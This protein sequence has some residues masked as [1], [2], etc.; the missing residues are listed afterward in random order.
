M[1]LFVRLLSIVA[2]SG[3]LN[4]V[5]CAPSSVIP[6][7]ENHPAMPNAESGVARPASNTLMVG[8]RDAMVAPSKKN[9]N[10]K[11]MKG[12]NMKDMKGHNMKDMS[13]PPDPKSE[14]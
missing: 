9:H 2:V 13:K 8:P 1:R 4:S 7:G 5:G 14:K 3:F 6:Q 10:M 12:H 11:D